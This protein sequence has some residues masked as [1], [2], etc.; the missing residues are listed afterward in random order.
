MRVNA[1]AAGETART[2]LSEEMD[3][4]FDPNAPDVSLATIDMLDASDTNILGDLVT[5]KM[6]P[7]FAGVAEANTKVRV[8]AERVVLGIPTGVVELIG[9]GV[10]SGQIRG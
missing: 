9:Q 10:P 3:V 4:H 5:S 7:A 6:S 1:A 2:Q 8:F